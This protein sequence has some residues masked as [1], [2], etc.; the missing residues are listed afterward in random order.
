LG[1]SCTGGFALAGVHE[2]A[3]RLGE[4]V[5]GMFTAGDAGAVLAHDRH[6]GLIILTRLLAKARQSE[7]QP[8]VKQLEEVI[9]RLGLDFVEVVGNRMTHA[10]GIL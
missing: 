1:G 2:R 5:G 10:R 8:V 9:A 6:V 3:E 7:A 4:V